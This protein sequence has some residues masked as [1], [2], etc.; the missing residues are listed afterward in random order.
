MVPRLSVALPFSR[1]AMWACLI[2]VAFRNAAIQSAFQGGEL[3][4]EVFSR[5]LATARGVANCT[6]TSSTSWR[7][8]CEHEGRS[9]TVP[10]C[11]PGGGQHWFA[12]HGASS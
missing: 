6:P 9:K 4:A 2:G 8:R 11:S 5:A 10:V 7:V 12:Q 1:W 3:G